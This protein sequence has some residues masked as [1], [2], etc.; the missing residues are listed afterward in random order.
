MI[1][2]LEAIVIGAWQLTVP[3]Q[4]F[5]LMMII[6]TFFFGLLFG[7]LNALA[8]APFGKIAGVASGTIGAF[9][10]LLGVLVGSL[11]GMQFDGTVLPLLI[12]FAVTTLSALMLI[13]LF[14]KPRVQR[15]EVAH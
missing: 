11:I 4:L 13:I 7:N 14:S 12:G 6:T 9:T 2:L 1:S 15:V 10:M 3:L 8:M 5:I